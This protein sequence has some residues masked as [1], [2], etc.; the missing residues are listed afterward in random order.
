M[1]EC[2]AD[3]LKYDPEVRLTSQQLLNHSYIVETTPG[4]VPSGPQIPSQL[5]ASLSHLVNGKPLQQRSLSA[6]TSMNSLTPRSI[7]PSHA[8]SP[9][10]VKP[11]FNAAQPPLPQPLPQQGQAHRVPFYPR[12]VTDQNG[13]QTVVS[14]L[15]APSPDSTDG[16]HHNSDIS[17]N[18]DETAAVSAVAS[19]VYS[20]GVD[21]VTGW[22]N[23]SGHAHVAN[24]QDNHEQWDAMD[25][26]SLPP[27]E[28]PPQSA[29]QGQPMDITL[30]SPMAPED[31][32]KPMSVQEQVAPMS[33]IQTSQTA[34]SSK[35]KLGL[36]FGKKHSK[37]GLSGMFG[38]GD[39]HQQLAPVDENNVASTMSTPSLKRTQSSSTDSRSVSEVNSPVENIVVEAPPPMDAKARK[40]EADRIA[41]EAELQRRALA[42]KRIR[43]QSRAVMQKRN[44]MIK[45][46]HGTDF[47]W[48]SAAPVNFMGV[49]KKAKQR[50]NVPQAS[51]SSAT[52]NAAGGRFRGSNEGKEGT[53]YD[54]FREVDHRTKARRRDFDDDHSMSSSEVQSRMSVISF[55]TVDSDPSSSRLRHRPSLFGIT[56]MRSTSSLQN[57]FDD[58]SSSAR[59]SNSPSF[60]QQLVS[61]FD[62]RA[63]M[64]SYEAARSSISS[65]SS[66]PPIHSLSLSSPQ[67]HA[68]ILG[69]QP[70]ITLPPPL[71][72]MTHQHLRVPTP[73]SPYEYGQYGIQQQPPSPAIAPHPQSNINPMFKVVSRSLSISRTDPDR[74]FQ[75]LPPHQGD[76]ASV[77]HQNTL[78]PFS[79]LESIAE[80]LPPLGRTEETH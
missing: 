29:G 2:I 69:R 56:Q 18:T 16:M 60:E 37:W 47:D 39:K 52:I 53:E 40:K 12:T 80:P 74:V 45:Q 49:Q 8:D 19:S 22:V 26:S 68:Q 67:Q 50:S 54:N 35:L 43:E 36:G 55:A 78:P 41:R 14:R 61:D 27:Q 51:S 72:S 7:P 6:A 70:F 79:Q 13:Q 57:S 33:A 30:T 63:S 11:P 75:P 9:A 77:R 10:N 76:G 58:F 28:R 24:G 64:S 21:R 1:V 34:S 31:P 5:S 38:H 73:S 15:A 59:S 32:T 3:L 20:T 4:N 66:P 48:E 17:H 46:K 42:E 71:P 23:G 44:Q 62:S 25:V 65:T